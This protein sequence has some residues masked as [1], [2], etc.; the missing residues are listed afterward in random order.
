MT[1][2]SNALKVTSLPGFIDELGPFLVDNLKIDK[3]Q[4][5]T[6]SFLAFS[7]IKS[8][9]RYI[10]QLLEELKVTVRYIF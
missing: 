6:F 9:S 3:V 4:P 2:T 10:F 7:G 8:N 5:V 1:V